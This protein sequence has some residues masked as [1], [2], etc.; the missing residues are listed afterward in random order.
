MLGSI[1]ISSDSILT[2]ISYTGGNDFGEKYPSGRPPDKRSNLFMRSPL[3]GA[4]IF[5]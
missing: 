4:M 2:S 3:S 1:L 5:H